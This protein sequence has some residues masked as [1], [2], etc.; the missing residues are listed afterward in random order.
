MPSPIGYIQR[1][2]RSKQAPV[3]IG[4]AMVEQPVRQHEILKRGLFP[5]QIQRQRQRPA[6]CAGRW[7]CAIL[8]GV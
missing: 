8:A 3:V 5:E 2:Q 1:H 6:G 4:N 7:L